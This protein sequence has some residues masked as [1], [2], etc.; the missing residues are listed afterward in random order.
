VG[1]HYLLVVGSIAAIGGT[2]PVLNPDIRG[3]IRVV[4]CSTRS[5]GPPAPAVR[6]RWAVSSR[7]AI[8]IL[9]GSGPAVGGIGGS[10]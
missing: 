10:G 5:P 3:M 6:D 2:S 1:G 8:A 4:G 7:A 9:S